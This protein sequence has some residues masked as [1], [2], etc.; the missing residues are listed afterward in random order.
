MTAPPASRRAVA[1]PVARVATLTVIKFGGTALAT[2]ARIRRAAL[3]VRALKRGGH[4]PIVVVSATGHTT[5]RLLALL[6]A[7][8]RG[9]TDQVCDSSRERDRALATGEDLSAALLAAAL[10]GLGVPALSLRGGEAGIL[11]A[12]EFGAGRPVVLQA[13]RLKALVA[14]G[15]VPVVAGFQATRADGETVTLGRG[16]SDVSAVFLAVAL[17]AGECRIVTDVDG[18]YSADPRL[19]PAASRFEVLEHR[20]LVR[21]AGAGAAVV[22]PDAAARAAQAGMLLRVLHFDAPLRGA[23]GTVVRTRRRDLP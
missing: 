5:D 16:G 6:D 17:G 18:V 13:N 8:G 20:E 22:H 4:H 14:G 1:A 2:A 10:L 23:A 11:A 7:V 15:Q 3:R 19:D 12:G 9:P 21:L